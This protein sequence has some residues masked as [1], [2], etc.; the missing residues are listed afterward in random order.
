MGAWGRVAAVVWIP[1]F[2]VSVIKNAPQEAYR[3][4]RE[5]QDERRGKWKFGVHGRLQQINY[6]AGAR[7]E[8]AK[9]PY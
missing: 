6:T 8:A 5:Y 4:G 7:K 1:S 3:R 2:E 9:N